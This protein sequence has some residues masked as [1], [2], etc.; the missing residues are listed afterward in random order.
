M[1]PLGASSCARK[2]ILWS[3]EQWRIFVKT[4]FLTFVSV[5]A[6]QVLESSRKTTIFNLHVALCYITIFTVYKIYLPS[7]PDDKGEFSFW[8]YIK[9]VAFPGLTMPADL[10]TLFYP[11]LLYVLLSPREVLFAFC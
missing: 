7:D 1:I 4:W 10:I 6:W 2:T 5:F 9:V 11:V 8:W 3:T